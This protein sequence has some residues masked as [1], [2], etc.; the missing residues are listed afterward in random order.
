MTAVPARVVGLEDR[1][2]VREGAFADLVV[3]DASTVIDGASFESP[4]KQATGIRQVIV[5]GSRVWGG[6]AW[7]GNRPGRI[8]KRNGAH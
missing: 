8:L 4:K 3:F 5:N 7:T 6:N 2:V 1:G